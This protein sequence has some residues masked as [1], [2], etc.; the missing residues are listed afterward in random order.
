MHTLIVK[1]NNGLK[2]V[3]LN[4]KLKESFVDKVVNE[5]LDC[6]PDCEW[7]IEEGWAEGSY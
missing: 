2:K 7:W 1:T 4:T 3:L 5:V 6:Y